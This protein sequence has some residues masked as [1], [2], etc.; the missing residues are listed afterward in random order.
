MVN[1]GKPS[2]LLLPPSSPPLLPSPPL[3][4]LVMPAELDVPPYETN[5][6]M[7]PQLV[8]V[9]LVRRLR[10]RPPGLKNKPKPVLKFLIP[11]TF[12]LEE[13][14][15]FLKPMVLNIPASMDVVDAIIDFACNRDVS[16]MVYNASGPI[17]KVTLCNLFDHCHDMFLQG[18]LHML[19]FSGF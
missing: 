9:A 10:G 17:S 15:D 14:E 12:R 13:K 8:M 4:T 5:E 11:T 18:N 6:Q 19:S 3:L 2:P 7:Q 16:I 1:N